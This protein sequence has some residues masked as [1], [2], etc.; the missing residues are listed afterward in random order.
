MREVGTK[1][2]ARADR[3]RQLVQCAVEEFGRHGYAASSLVNIAEGAGVSKAMIYHLFDSKEGLS[4]ACLE[5]VGPGLVSAVAGSQGTSDPGQRALDTFTAIFT[6][7]S[8]NRYAWAVIYDP[9]LPPGPASTTAADLRAQ[10]ESLGTVGTRQVLSAAGVDDPVDHE[11]FDRMW[12]SVVATAI[13]WWQ[14]HDELSADEMAVRCARLLGV[15]M[16]RT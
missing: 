7:L 2:V 15:I 8:D 13:H 12:Q 4:L 14:T 10:L 5:A 16:P 11:L 1:G 6:A 9:T 3:R